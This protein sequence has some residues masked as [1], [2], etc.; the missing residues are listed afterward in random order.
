MWLHTTVLTF[1]F[2][3]ISLGFG[4]FI[5]AMS[6]RALIA[7]SRQ[8]RAQLI[9]LGFAIGGPGTAVF[10]EVLSLVSANLYAD[11]AILLIISLTGFWATRD[12]WRPR[13]Q[14]RNELMLWTAISLPMALI[15]WWWSFGAFSHF[16]FGDIGADVHW[17]KTA[18]EFADTGMLNPYSEPTYADLRAGLAGT[19]SGTLGLDLLQ[20]NWVYR[21][22][23]ILYFMILF[24]A[25]A[26]SIFQDPYRKWFAFFFAAASNTL[27]LLTNGSLAVTSS[28]VFLSVLLR[29]DARTEQKTS[30]TTLLIAGSVCL[31]VVLAYYLNN[32][33]LMLAS[34]PALFLIFNIL[35]R[36]GRTGHNVATNT[37][38][39]VAWAMA[40]ILAHRGSYLFV[41]IAVTGWL[42]YVAVSTITFRIISPL[43]KILWSLALLL[44]LVC[45]CMLAWV[46][47]ARLGYLPLISAN[48]L[49]SYVTLIVVG[50]PIA[51]GDD[52][53]LGAGPEVAA[54]EI[55]RA[56]GPLFA[57]GAGLIV[58][59]WCATHRPA[60]LKQ[61]M[62][63][64]SP[65][66]NATRLLWSWIMGCG[67]CVAVL[68]GFPFLYRIIFVI[69]GFFT[70]AA[71]ELFGQLL[72]DPSPAP[73]KARRLVAVIAAIVLAIIVAGLYSFGWPSQPPN[74]GYQAI[75][76]PFEIAGVVL[77]LLFAALTFTR[78]RQMQIYALTAVIGLSIAID[79][80]G[81]STLFKTYSYGRLPDH[82]ATVSHYN[83]SDL[84]AGYWLHDNMRKAI[85]VSD[86]YTIA[87]AR[88][89]AGAPAIYAFSNLDTI[90]DAVASQVKDIISTIIERDISDAD[91]APKACAFLSPLMSNLIQEA[92]TQMGWSDPSEGLFRRVRPE[93]NIVENG[94]TEFFNAAKPTETENEPGQ[95]AKSNGLEAI[96]QPM[97]NLLNSPSGKWNVV[98]IINPRTIQWIHSKKGQRLSYFPTDAPLDREVWEALHGGPFRALFS[99]EQSAIILLDC[100]SG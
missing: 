39:V 71:T 90:N 32:N 72:V 60:S 43:I 64:P 42:F 14:D 51:A 55:G 92:S 69:M 57:V 34:L 37:F 35:N 87:M 17:I 26:D 36:T 78:S 89:I 40:L 21:Y 9:A 85:L 11:L 38:A 7:E 27:G 59:W 24:Y 41:P 58:T 84:R 8:T 19:L 3:L 2:F 10:L 45:I 68:C 83:A 61:L 75:L 79:R 5:L 6:S 12:F 28:L 67:L 50:K 44:P 81:V 73:V 62:N 25:V 49:F 48:K 18:Q 96:A 97:K 4:L 91:K 31:S 20:F 86:P 53:I 99:D 47:G 56:I 23:S 63:F 22:A 30:A 46:A 66:A 1:L 54:I 94:E 82:A 74:S 77:V 88:A 33:A 65:S 15:T 16:P 13:R 93:A 76:R 80:S 98:A 29:V 100:D 52:L 95:S 70:I